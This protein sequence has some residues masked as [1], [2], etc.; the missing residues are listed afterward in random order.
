MTAQF[1]QLIY[2]HQYV[3]LEKC[4]TAFFHHLKTSFKL[5]DDISYTLWMMSLKMQKI[6]GQQ[7]KPLNDLDKN[8]LSKIKTWTACFM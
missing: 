6:I 5:Y 8:L 4:F 3:G 2:Y 7:I 1:Q